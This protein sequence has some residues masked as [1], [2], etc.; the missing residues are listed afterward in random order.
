MTQDLFRTQADTR[1]NSFVDPMN[2]VNTNPG[3]WGINSSYLTPSYTAPY[4]PQYQG[5]YGTPYGQARQPGFGASLNATLNPFSSQ[6]ENYGGN[7]YQQTSAYFDSISQTPVTAAASATQ[8]F[9][10]P[11]AATIAAYTLLNR[12]S[13]A[14]GAWA[15]SSA[16]RGVMRGLGASPSFAASAG[17]GMGKLGGLAGDA[18]L[19]AI[20]V[21]AAMAF[22]NAMVFKPFVNQ[23]QTSNNVRR[24]FS[25][26]TFGG[27]SYGNSVTG[28]GLSR[29]QSAGIAGGIGHIG[30]MDQ[31]FSMDE[32]SDMADS[33]IRAGLYDNT[34]AK[35]LVKKTQQIVTQI[36]TIMQFANTSDYKEAIELMA[37]IQR[38]GVT[39]GT[40]MT[41]F[42]T[43]MGGYAAGAGVSSQRLMNT[44]GMQGQYLYGANGLTPAMGQL[45]A[46]RSYS[47]FMAAN[48]EGLISQSLLAQMG[49]AEGATQS[50]LTGQLNA[51]Q[52]P[53]AQII[54]YNAK[55]AKDGAATSVV[56]NIARFGNQAVADPLGTFGKM[57]L[58]KGDITSGLANK[59]PKFVEAMVNNMAN[60]MSVH[61]NSK[62][63]ITAEQEMGMLVQGMGM[64]PT[65][66]RALIA[67]QYAAQDPGT[68]SQ[69]RN[70]IRKNSIDQTMGYMKTQNLN[71]GIV[72]P[73]AQTVSSGWRRMKAAVS[74][75]LAAGLGTT[76][77]VGDSLEKTWNRDLYG[78]LKSTVY[79]SG[80]GKQSGPMTLLK[81]SPIAFGGLDGRLHSDK[82]E[83]NSNIKS[84]NDLARN[85]D[86]YATAFI[87]NSMKGG[88]ANKRFASWEALKKQGS[89]TGGRDEYNHLAGT[90][91]HNGTF[92]EAHKT[93]NDLLVRR[94][95]GIR[96]IGKDGLA[97]SMQLTNDL[98]DVQKALASTKDPDEQ[99]KILTKFEKI[100]GKTTLENLTDDAN[101]AMRLTAAS[102]AIGALDMFKA[103]GGQKET[104]RRA[105]AK[106]ISQT[107]AAEQMVSGAV[108]GPKV[109]SY[110]T[111]DGATDQD[112]Q[113]LEQQRQS[114]KA[115]Q[116]NLNNAKSGRIN[117]D[118]YKQN[119]SAIKNDA[120]VDKF[121]KAVDVF[122]GKV[123]GDS[124]NGFKDKVDSTVS[125]VKN[126]FSPKTRDVKS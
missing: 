1:F 95:K 20:P 43:S 53:Y 77:G 114:N 98:L 106:H 7:T 75:G 88:D 119:E 108:I 6:G 12:P 5:S 112:A 120:A 74:D 51:V 57:E 10:L 28:G 17:A 109:K 103:K 44:V 31:T 94:M 37:N 46:G 121:A 16:T 42:T 85:G 89:I 60:N 24:D 56:G 72:T 61:R 19:P 81:E 92:S 3:N 14:L 102:G 11:A 110:D 66:A 118:T 59:G 73:Y 30:A 50:S 79:H 123:T 15:A 27:N 111:S 113:Y 47:S 45:A 33:S 21:E 91:N 101:K 100:H 58:Y 22:S 4:R 90:I 116:D 86:K 55:F 26:V 13:S 34:K 63:Q 41:K 9:L 54:G 48:R 25:G 99:I 122:V 67:E 78:N 18:F 38:S 39:V 80:D 125:S 49:G 2:P 124:T 87:K 126:Y 52:S 105:K 40:Q 70:G 8:N 36:K 104:A 82:L 71:M 117:F 83:D 93:D 29:R 32:V 69:L 96:G 64:D 35:D 115:L 23:M 97:Q 76:G 84:I 68:A 62:G 107:Q 65:S